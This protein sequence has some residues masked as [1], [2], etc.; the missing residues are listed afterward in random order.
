MIC[1]EFPNSGV[2]RVG[3]T[4]ITDLLS[5]KTPSNGHGDISSTHLS[6]LLAYS[7]I[8]IYLVY[9]NVYGKVDLK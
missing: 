1:R 5:C 2:I 6:C 3:I 4:P 9:G 8:H 7:F